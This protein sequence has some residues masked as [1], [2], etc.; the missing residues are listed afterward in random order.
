MLPKQRPGVYASRAPAY[1]V[2]LWALLLISVPI[3][4]WTVGDAALP[5]IVSATVITLASAMVLLLITTLGL[6]SA[7]TTTGTILVLTWLLEFAGSKTGLLFGRYH[8][9]GALQ[10]QIAG[11]PL[12]IP[13]AWLMMLPAAWAAA[14]SITGRRTGIAYIALSALAFTAWDLYL[15]PQ[16]VAWGFWRW[17]EPGSYFGIPWHNYLGWLLSAALITWL[18]GRAPLPTRLPLAV[19]ALTWILQAIGLGLFWQMP[20]PALCGFVGMGIPLIT[21]YAKS[22][23]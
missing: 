13:F 19:Y 4:R 8:Y 1:L 9:T 10:P 20:G 5:L 7:I 2:A 11:V 15:D 16:M 12:I 21:G 14:A 3:V 23:Q 22:R 18:A 17:D 6:R